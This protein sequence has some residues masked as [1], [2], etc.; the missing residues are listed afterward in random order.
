MKYFFLSSRGIHLFNLTTIVTLY[1]Q[2]S[3]E[4]FSLVNYY[5]NGKPLA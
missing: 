2:F 1:I 4:I 3:F 5:T